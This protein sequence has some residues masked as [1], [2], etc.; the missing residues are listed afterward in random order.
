MG[1]G[2]DI[3]VLAGC[4]FQHRREISGHL[5]GQDGHRLQQ[6]ILINLGAV[7]PASK[8]R[9]QKMIVK[10]NIGTAVIPSLAWPIRNNR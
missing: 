8:L 2:D 1:Y 6:A 3:R 9:D 7:E 5:V 4:L 10:D